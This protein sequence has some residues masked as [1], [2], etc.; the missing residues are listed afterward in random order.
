MG[1]QGFEGSGMKE[2]L[3]LSAQVGRNFKFRGFQLD[4]I[5]QC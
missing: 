1:Y 5:D 2:A 4:I 3:D